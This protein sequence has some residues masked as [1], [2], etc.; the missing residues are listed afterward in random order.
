MIPIVLA[1][2]LAQDKATFEGKVVNALTN[3]PL[4]K[5]RVVLDGEKNSY[6]VTS[7]SEGTFRFEGIEPG[8][9]HPEAQRQGF[10]DSDDEPWIG[11]EPGEHMKDAVIKMTPQGV[12]AGH[13]VDE[14]GDPVPSLL[15]AATRSIHV[16]GRAVSLGRGGGVT[17]GEGYFLVSELPAG[18]YYLSVEPNLREIH[19]EQPG[20]AGAEERFVHTDDAVPRDITPGAA[21][22]NVEIHITKTTV[23]R[24]RGRVTNPPPDPI[25]ISLT[26][27][28][29]AWGQ[30]DY[31][32][33]LE[34]GTFE[35][36]GIP[37]GSYVIHFETASQFCRIPVT[38]AD[39][40][41]DGIVAELAPHPGLEGTIKIEGGGRFPKPPVIGFAGY[42]SE[43]V[44]KQDGTF[45]MKNLAPRK[46]TLVYAPPDGFYVK[47]IQFNHQPLTGTAIDLNASG[48]LDILV[49]PNAATIAATARDA[50]NFKVTL[51]SDTTSTTKESDDG[52]VSFMNLAPGEYR[53]LA[54]ERI[55]EQYTRVP[56]FLARFDAQKIMLTEGAH[57]NIEVKLIPKSVTD[58]EIA[59]LQ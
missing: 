27:P 34:D 41:I 32:A 26:P 17:D 20:H 9:Y 29:G 19:L 10:L 8:D 3:E 28:D 15:V 22:R 49:A 31:Q 40:N 11:L 7:T 4:R 23:F 35:F 46:Y 24:I 16:N 45:E 57:E 12:I 55:D 1:L 38:V 5:A 18:R 25:G 36:T 52:A 54:W 50:K 37:P 30:N 13:V 58:A 48:K 2:L 43:G 39:R 47:S 59:K 21:L 51:W 44:A 53:I 42:S 6:A 33:R 14:D 56:E